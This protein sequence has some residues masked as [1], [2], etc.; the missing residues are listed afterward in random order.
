[1]PPTYSC[2]NCHVPCK[3]PRDTG[4]SSTPHSFGDIYLCG[5]CGCVSSFG[6]M[7]LVE[8]TE[9]EFVSLTL[10]EKKELQFAARQCLKSAR[11]KGEF[12]RQT[13][14]QSND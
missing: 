13:F 4:L 14:L 1:M 3:D 8:L 7:Q 10:D 5:D 11:N 9:T 2:P 6:L 12:I